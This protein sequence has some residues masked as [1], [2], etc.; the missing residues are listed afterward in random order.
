MPSNLTLTQYHGSG[1][2]NNGIC[3]LQSWR[4][5]LGAGASWRE[6]LPGLL[7]M[8]TLLLST[9][10]AERD[11]DCEKE[12]GGRQRHITSLMSCY[13]DYTSWII[14]TPVFSAK[15]IIMLEAKK[16]A[17]TCAWLGSCQVLWFSL[18]LKY[19]LW[20]HWMC[21]SAFHNNSRFLYKLSFIFIVNNLL[22]TPC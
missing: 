21:S 6:P 3:V 18:P 7:M 13:E 19:E 22:A 11:R 2:F 1:G 9:H 15:F 5:S 20:K 4:L 17:R 8:A 12:R 16:T 14:N 10:M